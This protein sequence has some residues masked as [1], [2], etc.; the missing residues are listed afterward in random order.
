MTGW[1]A[2]HLAEWRASANGDVGGPGGRRGARRRLWAGAVAASVLAHVL[3]LVAL[4]W[5]P[6][7]RI[8]GRAGA[9]GPFASAITVGLTSLPEVARVAAAPNPAPGYLPATAPRTSSSKDSAPQDGTSGA[10]SAG[11]GPGDDDG[12]YR[13]PFRDAVAQ[14]YASLRGGLGCAHVD[15]D[16]LPASVR[17]L[18]LAGSKLGIASDPDTAGPADQERASVEDSLRR[19]CDAARADA[20][21][22][23]PDRRLDLPLPLSLCN[24]DPSFRR[25]ATAPGEPRD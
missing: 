13:V 3:V 20:R 25:P 24:P 9:A 4:A 8:G 6:K 12:I 16:R 5:A 10:G 2:E 21:P 11:P 1:A 14:A 19:I 22:A 23:H 7:E 17:D 15:L 18:C